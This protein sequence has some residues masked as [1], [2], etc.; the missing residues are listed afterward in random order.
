MTKL[1]Q[2]SFLKSF[3]HDVFAEVM[4]AGDTVDVAVERIAVA[5]HDLAVGLLV[6]RFETGD[7]FSVSHRYICGSVI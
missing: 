2:R 3:A 7:Q 1:L 4:I 5:G 6:V